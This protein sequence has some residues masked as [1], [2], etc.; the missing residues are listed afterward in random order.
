MILKNFATL[1]NGIFCNVNAS[2]SDLVLLDGS[3]L[4]TNSTVPTLGSMSTYMKQTATV[5]KSNS[6]V[7][8]NIGLLFGAGTTPPTV[9]DYALEAMHTDFTYVSLAKTQDGN[10]CILTA[11]ITNSQSTDLTVSEIGCFLGASSG[12]YR[13]NETLIGRSVITPVTIAPGASQTF[14][15]TLDFDAITG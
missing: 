9:S 13:Y 2:N 6:F 3:S 1:L 11:V 12:N 15:Y 5:T 8:N 4:Q 14:I 10:K 7:F